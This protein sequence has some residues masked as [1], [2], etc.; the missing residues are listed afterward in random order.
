MGTVEL[1]ASKDVELSTFLKL[2]NGIKSF[3]SMTIVKI[4]LTAV[5]LFAVVY[6]VLVYNNYKKKKKRRM[7]REQNYYDNQ[8]E[9]E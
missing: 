6:G 7:Q 4:I 2:I 9:T 5:V 1:V 8:N 3:F